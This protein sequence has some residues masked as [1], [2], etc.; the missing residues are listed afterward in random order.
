MVA[1]SLIRSRSR[2]GASPLMS[3]ILAMNKYYNKY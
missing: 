3:F 1:N 2:V